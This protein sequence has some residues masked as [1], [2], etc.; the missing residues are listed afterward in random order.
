MLCFSQEAFMVWFFFLMIGSLVSAHAQS[1]LW[2]SPMSRKA[3]KAQ[4]VLEGLDATI[5]KA[6]VD[7]Q[8]PG[9]A[10]GIVVDGHT[11][12]LNGYG[13]RDLENKTKVTEDTL[14]AIGSCTKAFTTFALGALIEEGLL[15]WDSPVIDVLP[16]FRLWDSYATQNVTLRDFVTHRS[17]VPRHDFMW[18]NAT[19]SRQ[20]LLQRIRYLEPTCNLRERYNY[21]NL[22]YLI[23]GLAMEK[24][25]GTSWE[26]VVSEKILQPLGMQNTNF[27][28]EDTRKSGNYALPYLEK[29]GVLKQ[30]PFRDFT[31]VGPACSM[32][33]S[34]KEM[35]SWIKMLLAQGLYDN[36]SLLSSACIQEMFAAQAI[37]SG[38]VENQDT[39]FN[40]YGLGWC[41][42]S[43]RGH[44]SVSHDGG[45]DGFTAVVTLLPYDNLGIVVLS[46]KNLINLPRYLSLEIID[47]ILELPVRDWLQQGLDQWNNTKKGEET[48]PELQ[49]KM[50]T[51][52]THPLEEYGGVY[53]HPGYG[54]LDVMVKDGKLQAVHNGIS[55]L[56]D[57]WHY[58]VFSIREDTEELL[59]SRKGMKFSFHMNVNGEIDTLSIPFEPKTS[60]IVFHKKVADNFSNLSYCRRFVGSY[61]IYGLVCE[62]AIRDNALIAIIPGQPIYELVPV[63][64]NEFNVKS[65]LEYAVRF[66]KD[67]AGEFSQVLLVSPYGAYTAH[68]KH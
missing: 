42:H 57:H 6:L 32:N 44:Y 39:H 50:G 27:S 56:L 61:E 59:I 30:I 25:K 17:G 18:Y 63:N 20:E 66:V 52:P 47:R 28:L 40:A 5:E 35:V 67:D 64:D 58:D 11:I 1:W 19:H 24:V 26:N 60:P 14:F 7:F 48:S 4:S 54:T 46:N 8:V 22:S 53:E 65:R 23:T 2:D 34:V 41:I 49:R 12:W 62:F 29:R 15:N 21:G 13:F 43:Y 31:S 38:Y 37:I 55:S 10:V 16:D 45:I 68:R 51:S 33:S 36:R 9:L 3:V